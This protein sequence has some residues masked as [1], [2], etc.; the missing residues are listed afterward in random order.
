[1][2]CPFCKKGETSVVDSRPTEDGTSIRRRRL[3]SCNERFTT[4]ERVQFRELTV[5]KKNG[6]KSSFDREKLSKS[7]YIAL[8]KRPIDSDTVEKFITKISRSLE[9]LGQSEISS[10]I[11]GTMVMDGL[12]E[13][14]PVAYVRFA[15]VYRNFREEKDFVQFVDKINV[16]KNK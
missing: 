4:F 16:I 7:I 2:I 10:S 6:R 3:C 5:V 15:S 11:I 9:E 14:D 1:M 8:K 12:K 13:I